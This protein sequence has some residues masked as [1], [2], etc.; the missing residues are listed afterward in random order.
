MYHWYNL[1]LYS[2]LGTHFTYSRVQLDGIRILDVRSTN[3]PPSLNEYTTQNEN[4]TIR[5]EGFMH[6][7]SDEAQCPHDREVG[8]AV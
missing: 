3:D 6:G 2:W 4:V 7:S 1:Y 8:C 5:L